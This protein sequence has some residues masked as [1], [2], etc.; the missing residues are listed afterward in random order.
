MA[1]FGGNAIDAHLLGEALAARLCHDLAGLAG[2]VS[3]LL[4]FADDASQADE[5]IPLARDAARQLVRRLRVA[6]AAWGGPEQW[7][8]AGLAAA[9]ADVVSPELSIVLDAAT[10]RRGA[11]AATGA[12]LLNVALL[13]MDIMRRGTIRFAAGPDE[14]VIATLDST[15]SGP[16]GEWPTLRPQQFEPGTA[17]PRL[18]QLRWTAS[19]AASCGASLEPAG[20]VLRIRLPSA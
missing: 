8:R 11:E 7:P 9:V 13:G 16:Q 15:A 18:F 10:T 19:M 2:T 4:E 1:R 17:K 3:N 12:L 20:A 5:A 6:R 14:D